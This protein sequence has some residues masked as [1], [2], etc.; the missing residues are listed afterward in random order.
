M[1]K[2]LLTFWLLLVTGST[3]AQTFACQYVASAGLD[4]E[5]GSWVTRTFHVGKPFFL[6]LTLDGKN[7][8][9]KSIKNLIQ[10]ATCSVQNEALGFISC[11]SITGAFLYFNPSIFRGAVTRT[12]GAALGDVGDK[13]S[14]S[15]APF[16]C[17]KM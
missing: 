5:N 13:D 1:T 7:I 10:S 11:A 6:N 9:E 16:I 12:L 17:Q 2:F 3:V 4:W 8:E 15:V 14:V